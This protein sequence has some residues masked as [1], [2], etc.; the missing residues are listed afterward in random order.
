M[1]RV[2]FILSAIAVAVLAGCASS[3]E[4]GITSPAPAP[5]PAR[6]AAAPAAPTYSVGAAGTTVVVPS[7]SAGETVSPA[8]APT[9]LRV[10]F[11]RIESIQVAPN[12]STG[13]APNPSKRLALRMD[14]GTVQNFDTNA[15]GIAVGDRVEITVNGTLRHPG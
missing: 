1:N 8:A 11:G 13:A 3:T 10:G 5:A 2:P 4:S 7:A 12:A 9:P 6:A 15:A 14:D